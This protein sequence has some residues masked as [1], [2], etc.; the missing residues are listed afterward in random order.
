MLPQQKLTNPEKESKLG[1]MPSPWLSPGMESRSLGKEVLGSRLPPP[2]PLT[3]APAGAS[4]L[5]FLPQLPPHMVHSQQRSQEDAVR[6]RVQR[7]QSPPGS[8]AASGQ[9]AE[10]LDCP[11]SL[12]TTHPP[13]NPDRLASHAPSSNASLLIPA[14][15]L[16]PQG[17]CA[18]LPPPLTNILFWDSFRS[19]EKLSTEVLVHPTC[20]SISLT[21]YVNMVPLL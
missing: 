2:S 12:H 18:L 20:G 13:P 8:V 9:R 3:R 15:T 10:S 21:S 16:L 7:R 14:G 1:P 17:L 6:T 19:T 5:V 11:S 4:S